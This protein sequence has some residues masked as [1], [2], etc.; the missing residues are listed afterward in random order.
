MYSARQFSVFYS[1][2]Q[3][4]SGQM[5]SLLGHFRSPQLSCR[6]FLWRDRLLPQATD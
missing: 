6:H 3:T 5:T 4:T 1:Y 2:F